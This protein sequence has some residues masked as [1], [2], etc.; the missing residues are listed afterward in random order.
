VV[1]DPAAEA[2]LHAALVELARACRVLETADGMPMP[3][4]G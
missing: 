1:T 3:L 2:N 4:V